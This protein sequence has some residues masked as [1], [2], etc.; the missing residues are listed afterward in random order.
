MGVEANRQRIVELVVYRIISK[1]D[2]L[3]PIVLEVAEIL[4]SM[5]HVDL[6]NGD[7]RHESEGKGP[8]VC[9]VAKASGQVPLRD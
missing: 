3:E 1:G 9:G 2:D 6:K 8:K 4:L 7:V 5:H